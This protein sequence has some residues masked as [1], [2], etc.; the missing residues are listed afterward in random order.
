VSDETIALYRQ[1]LELWEGRVREAPENADARESL[2]AA[3]DAIASE[4]LRIQ[5]WAE[6][7]RHWESA[8]E[9][10]EALTRDFPEELAYKSKLALN[11]RNL[12]TSHHNRQQYDLARKY[13]ERAVQLGR[14]LV[15]A[16]PTV[17]EYQD[18][19]DQTIARFSNAYSNWSW[20]LSTAADVADRDPIK[21]VELAQVAIELHPHS[22]NN[23]NNLG[24]AQYRAGNWQ[25]A[26]EA[27]EKADSM[28]PDGDREHR[29]FLAMAHW[30]LG[31]KDK[32]RELYTQG[33][34]WI[35]VHGKGIEEQARFQA[36]AEQL[37]AN[38][39]ANQPDEESTEHP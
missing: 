20:A 16:A 8:M 28:I 23:W 31:D 6:M 14:E 4:S 27:L 29:M 34:G 32:A 36:E 30:Q 11:C 25:A 21:A 35:A 3:H 26:V 19:L 5:Q 33:A 22:A 1:L 37:L 15:A 38:P 13:H 10:R 7:H 12:A 17:K 9:I 2:A 24:V 18:D 39:D